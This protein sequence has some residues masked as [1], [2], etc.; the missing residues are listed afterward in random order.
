[1][2]SPSTNIVYKI[3]SE[4]WEIELVHRL[5]YATFVEE[6][7]QHAPN[8]EGRLVDR[9]HAENT[10]LIALDG[11]TLAGMMALRRN[12]PFSLDSKVPELDRHLP[13]GRVPIEVRLLA[14]APDYR[15]SPVF[16][17]LFEQAVRYCISEGFD[18]ALISGT[19][20][21][22]RLYRHIGFV[23]FGPLV[24]TP[25]APY[26]P[27]Y[28]TLEA[29][30]RT[31]KKSPVLRPAIEAFGARQEVQNFLP[32]PVC[33]APE[34]RD[35]LA[36][37]ADS[38][39]GQDFLTRI[40]SIRRNLC[41]MTQA[42]D[43]QVLVGS[44]SL[45]NAV[46]AAQLGLMETTGLVISNGEFGERLAKEARRARLRFDWLRLSWGE[47]MTP[48]Q[49]ENAASRL[50]RGGWIWCVH[51]ETSTGVLNPMP[52]LKAICHRLG[53]HLCLDC[54]STIG[55]LPLDLSGVH[56]ATATS[57]KGLGSFPGLAMV[58]H[59]YRPAPQPQV[60]PS[61]IDLGE[62]A[63]HDSVP[64]THSSNLVAALAKAIELAT[65]ERQARI[66]SN[67]LW[68][69]Q[70]LRTMG[71]DLVALEDHAC[72]AIVSIRLEEP[73]AAVSLGEE[74]RARGFWLSY[75]SSYLRDQ[76]WI[77]VALLGDPSRESLKKL[78]HVLALVCN[79]KS[80]EALRDV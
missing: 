31:M 63:A 10:Y 38:H 80:V 41:L 46:V 13:S 35:A 7:P 73:G 22:L 27:M 54:I 4:D 28:L 25:D 5:N 16:T 37:P 55:A 45:A 42:R 36:T 44:G 72:P 48:G 1:M 24:G 19:T 43:V 20:R 50:P 74:L 78:V 79:R 75:A 49:I 69:R 60:L 70:S 58:F 32:G 23:P 29:F 67:G 56:L 68:L 18:I 9:F 52:Q 33:M 30:G 57:G 6:I 65:P 2:T 26:Q 17:E 77:Q 66:Q 62:W 51:H 40:A 12:R 14:V 64:F 11:Q 71:F 3:A 53:L 39:R 34:V 61:Y 76:N 15:K 59:D 8:L 47:P 21:Q